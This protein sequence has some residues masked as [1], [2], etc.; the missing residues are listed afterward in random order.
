MNSSLIVSNVDVDE[1]LRFVGFVVFV[2]SLNDLFSV[3]FVVKVTVIDS[4]DRFFSVEIRVSL[5][6][7]VE[8]DESFDVV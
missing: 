5:I 1:E 4:F 2:V 6:S 3:E 7:G 8:E